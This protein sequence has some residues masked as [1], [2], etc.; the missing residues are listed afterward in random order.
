[1][2]DAHEVRNGTLVVAVEG[3]GDTQTISLIGELDLSN[4]ESLSAALDQAEAADGA[5]VVIDMRRLEFIDST[6]IA[7]LVAC[8][9]RLNGDADRL[10]IVASQ[11]SAVRRVLSVTGLDASLPFVEAT[12]GADAELEADLS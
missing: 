11:A 6:G 10:R 5:T 8:H 9:R 7:L 1:M 3:G 12:D 2:S 4:A